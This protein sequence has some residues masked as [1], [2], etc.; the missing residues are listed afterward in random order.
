[1]LETLEGTHV[2]K[3]K[4]DFDGLSWSLDSLLKLVIYKVNS[5][6]PNQKLFLETL[7]ETTESLSDCA[8]IDHLDLKALMYNP[9][10]HDRLNYLMQILRKTKRKYSPPT[11]D[12]KGEV[13]PAFRIQEIINHID[14][15]D[16]NLKTFD[17]KLVRNLLYK[18][19]LEDENQPRFYQFDKCRL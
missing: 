11:H 16:G 15:T 13:S 2:A 4:S 12:I 19:S 5:E 14:T 7:D 6:Y 10:T 1:M 9:K 18:F 17:E 8:E 3:L